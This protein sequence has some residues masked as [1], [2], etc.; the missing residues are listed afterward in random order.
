MTLWARLLFGGLRWS[1]PMLPLQ[2]KTV[3]KLQ[4][5]PS[6]VPPQPLF[7]IRTLSPT[8]VAG[9]SA[10]KYFL[11]DFAA[12]TYFIRFPFRTIGCRPYT[13]R[14]GPNLSLHLHH[15]LSSVIPNVTE[16]VQQ[17]DFHPPSDRGAVD[18]SLTGD[19]RDAIKPLRNRF[20]RAA[21]LPSLQV[22]N[23]ELFVVG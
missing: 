23:W 4:L 9:C 12:G 19:A 14:S 11:L 21:A 15:R 6:W 18:Q 10:G 16:P 8:T 1:V 20:S 17:L 5:R 2:N 22:V 3:F 7:H 13:A